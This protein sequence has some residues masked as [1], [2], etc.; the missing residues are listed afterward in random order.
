M[1]ATLHM[2]TCGEP[3]LSPAEVLASGRL[4]ELIKEWEAAYDYVLFDVPPV[5]PITDPVIVATLCQG[6]S[7]RGAC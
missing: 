4:R 6:S 2:L 7:P 1:G 3:S 5:I